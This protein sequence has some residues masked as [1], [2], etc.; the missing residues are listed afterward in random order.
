MIACS[1][2]CCQRCRATSITP[3][4]KLPPPP[5]PLALPSFPRLSAGAAKRLRAGPTTPCDPDCTGRGGEA[6]LHSSRTRPGG[7]IRRPCHRGHHGRH[8]ALQCEEGRF[9]AGSSIYP[10][11]ALS[12]DPNSNQLIYNE[13]VVRALANHPALRDALQK[14]YSS[15]G[16]SGNDPELKS[17]RASGIWDLLTEFGGSGVRTVRLSCGSRMSHSPRHGRGRLGR[18]RH[19]KPWLIPRPG[20]RRTAARLARARPPPDQQST[21]A[22]HEETQRARLGSVRRVCESLL[23]RAT[24]GIH[25]ETGIRVEA[26]ESQGKIIP[27]WDPWPPEECNHGT[28]DRALREGARS[29]EGGR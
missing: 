6:G 14:G 21:D 1:P 9:N 2:S 27:E 19:H 26:A 29:P 8:G 24:D 15:E 23:A 5:P 28:C 17:A 20:P 18:S 11:L 16:K 22:T 13:A 4:P 10:A 12:F 3:S 7:C 25:E